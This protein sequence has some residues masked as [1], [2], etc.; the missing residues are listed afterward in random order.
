MRPVAPSETDE[1]HAFFVDPGVRRYWLDGISIER[2]R[3]AEFIDDSVESF[4]GRELGLW[5]AREKAQSS[6]IGLTGFREFREPPVL[7]L[8][9]G[10]LPDYWGRGLATEMGRAMLRLGFTSGKLEVVRTSIDAPNQASVRVIERIGL[11]LERRSPGE[12]WEQL[13]YVLRREA[14]VAGA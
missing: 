10:L 9:Y 14:W 12:I 8:L 13:H 1:L 6:I 4:A 11:R 3:V 2:A 5:A 7:E